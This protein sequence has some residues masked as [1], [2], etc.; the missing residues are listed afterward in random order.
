MSSRSRAMLAIL[1]FLF[2][3]A[4]C[5]A[6][7]S[8]RSQYVYAIAADGGLLWYEHLGITNGTFSWV[9]PQ[10]VGSG[11]Q[12]F[13][14]VMAAGDGVIYGVQ[15]DG[16][17]LWYK[18]WG[19][20]DGSV[21]WSG[22]NQVGSN[23]QGF[24]TVFSGGEGILY[25]LQ[26]DGTLV[27]YKHVDW[28]TGGSTWQGPNVVGVGWNFQAVF[29]GDGGSIYA[30]ESDG[31]LLWYRHLGRNDGSF[32][33][34]GPVVVGSAWQNFRTVFGGADGVIYA[35]QNDGTLVWYRHWGF[36][37]GSDSWSGPVVVGTGWALP[38][39]FAASEPIE[40]YCWPLSAAPGGTISFDASCV[41]DYQVTYVRFTRQGD[42]NQAIPLTPPQQ[43][44]A[45]VQ[46]VPS[47][48]WQN[49]C[50][51]SSNFQFQVPPSWGSGI[52]AAECTDVVGRSFDIVFIVKPLPG[53]HGN[54]AILA[55]TNTWNTYNPW[56]GEDKYSSPPATAVSYLR[57]NLGAAPFE[58]GGGPSHL[59]RAELWVDDWLSTTGYTFDTYTDI[60]MDQGIPGLSDY[61][62]LIIH[63]HPEYWTLPERNNLEA[64]IAGGG[65]VLYLGGNG[66]FEQV[67][68]SPDGTT[69][70]LFPGGQYPWRD[71]SYFRNIIPHR[72][73][74]NILGVAYRYDNYAT[75]AP[76]QVLQASHHLFAG[77]G[78]SNG[79]LIGSSGIN[80]GGA[81]GWE[82]DTSIPGNQ[83][84]SVIVSCYGADD[85]GTPPG[86]IQLLARGTNT[87][88]DGTF[89]A[90]M[91]YYT[92]P[93]G[94][95]VFT[96]G[97]I[98]FGGSLVIDSALQQIVRNALQD[99]MPLA[100]ANG[101][102]A[103]RTFE[104]SRNE[105]NPFR[106]STAIRYVLPS[107]SS[108]RL[109][110]FDVAGREVARLVDGEEEAG[111]HAV[112]W[113]GRKG[114]GRP[115]AAGVYVYRLESTDRSGA[116]EGKHVK[117]GRMVL[118][119]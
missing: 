37:D 75:W 78:L 36:L 85:R 80:G 59:G 24:R 100:D 39:V 43:V 61:K 7:A 72:P 87:G 76:F 48:P 77:T 93:A 109:A 14:H 26:T 69:Q 2:F 99:A 12:N 9:G 88:S 116:P 5:F 86:N 67:V 40:G 50:G 20:H 98:S 92:T 102:T 42:E 31:T 114:T 10:T 21:N 119:R 49:G 45:A 73:E 90:D 115:A 64:Y 106:S 58:S 113:D 91:T 52:Y 107:R 22:P 101:A 68:L 13:T 55:N 105:P 118:L 11:F 19:Y 104:L 38:A 110:V 65:S 74:R 54:F 70:T 95:F 56:G 15:P 108:V 25:G 89:G 112:S 62:A 82:M 18:H 103:S 41:S 23:W 111:A 57:P 53:Q 94:G 81:S 30:I 1:P 47:Q 6:P 32:S 4:L 44:S 8:A 34:A 3:W 66:L 71:P 28:E 51:W 63:T 46:A 97:S 35:V 96:A 60:D 27:W 83:P 33:W 16:T 84:D 79:D 29:P 17:L 117:S